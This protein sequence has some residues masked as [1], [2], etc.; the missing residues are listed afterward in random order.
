LIGK[1]LRQSRRVDVDRAIAMAPS[2]RFVCVRRPGAVDVIDIQGTAPRRAIACDGDFAVAGETLC[3][4]E[5]TTLR[6]IP[7]GNAPEGELELE[8]APGARIIPFAGRSADAILVGDAVVTLAPHPVVARRLG[9]ERRWFPLLG[10][11]AL[12][13]SGSEL[14]IG[15]CIRCRLAGDVEIE[16]AAPLFGGRLIGLVMRGAEREVAVITPAGQLVHR[17]ALSARRTAFAI[18]RGQLFGCAEDGRLLALDLRV[19]RVVATGDAPHAVADLAVDDAGRT[20][21]IADDGTGD[22]PPLVS[23]VR[24]TE[25]AAGAPPAPEIVVE[26][27]VV[28]AELPPRPEPP[29]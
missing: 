16:L 9:E 22:R 28:V 20:I 18:D 23:L 6:T 7:L 26:E 19:G 21:A 17:F 27:P 25:L 12:G 4:L 10:R 8:V 15:G 5:G 29:P 14:V 24:A 2:G 11:M 3:V 1:I 13:A